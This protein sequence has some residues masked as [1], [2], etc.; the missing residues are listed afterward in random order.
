MQT[1]AWAI[2]Y[3]DEKADIPAACHVY[4]FGSSLTKSHLAFYNDS[5]VKDK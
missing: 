4:Y 5:F 1:L 2:L 3:R